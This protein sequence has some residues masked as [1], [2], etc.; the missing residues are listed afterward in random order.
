MC[1][2]YKKKAAAAKEDGT[3]ADEVKYGDALQLTEDDDG[4]RPR[5]RESL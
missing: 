5:R 2:Q 4:C 1:G 3:L